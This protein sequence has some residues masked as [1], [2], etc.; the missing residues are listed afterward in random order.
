[1]Q[2]LHD[3]DDA[4]PLFVVET[5]QKRVVVPF[6]DRSAPRFR[7]GFVGLEWVIY[8]DDVGA[9]AGQHAANRRGHAGALLGRSE[10]MHRLA[11]REPGPKEML[12]PRASDYAAAVA[13]EFVGEIL[14]VAGAD[15]LGTR[16][17]PKTP[18]GE[19]D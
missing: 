14:P 15:D 12:I 6:V 9:T 8:N 13:G 1:M 16:I 5:T 7:E 2:P 3:N 11:I 17:V 19:G 18:G 4:A 10:I